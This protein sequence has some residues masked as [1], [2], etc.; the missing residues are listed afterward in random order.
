MIETDVVVVGGGPVG[1]AMATS[2][3][4]RG[5][6]CVVI[7][8][9][10]DVGTIPKG[11]NLSQ[12]SMELLYSWGCADT[13]RRSRVISR[14]IRIGGVTVYG[15]FTSPYW[16]LP[17]PRDSVKEFYFQE[18]ERL[19]QYI[20][21]TILRQRIGSL[22]TVSALFGHTAIDV[23]SNGSGADVEIRA[24]DT[25]FNQ[26]IV[27]GKYV[28]GCDGSRSLVRSKLGIHQDDRDL[29]R[30]MALIVF[31][32]R[33]LHHVLENYPLRTT[34]RIVKPGLGGL[35]HFFGR[36]DDRECWFYH[37]P[38][39]R[40]LMKGTDYASCYLQ[41]AVGVEIDVDVEYA[42]EWE[43]RIEVAESYQKGNT[44]IAGDAA[45]SHPP[46]GAYGLNTGLEDVANLSWKMVA[47]LEGWGGRRLLDSYDSERRAVFAETAE[48]ISEGIEE[49]RRFVE[50]YRPDNDLGGF[51]RVWGHSGMGDPARS[52]YVPHYDGSPVMCAGS[53]DKP[54]VRGIHKHEARVGYHLSPGRL[55]TGKDVFEVLGPG[56]T[57]LV[58]DEG[59]EGISDFQQAA[60]LFRV[61][62]GVLVVD[63]D[64]MRNYYGAEMVLVRPDQYVAWVGRYERGQAR[65]VL[66]RVTGRE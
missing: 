11:Q 22:S 59:H 36:V 56:F 6:A 37:G 41:N 43:C 57:L 7:E 8:R 12:R 1:L 5:V 30:T 64:M 26:D 27:R 38:I 20:L 54:G 60:A 53:G 42:G 19:P 33:A 63:S 3:G 39:S 40:S 10:L 49:E 62:L 44:F 48:V 17:E 51:L 24:N 34:Y 61:P 18:N 21:E 52:T 28:V 58:G 13:V 45:H 65:K 14:D 55:L 23:L 46:Y 66:T 15:D 9:H 2:L 25:P 31:R 16:Y 47:M 35:S 32:S 4:L 50:K 29:N